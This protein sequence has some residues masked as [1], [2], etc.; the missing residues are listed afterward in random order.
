MAATSVRFWTARRGRSR[1]VMV[2]AAAVLVLGVAG[3]AAAAI[4][5]RS[6]VIVG[7]YKT[8]GGGLRVIDPSVTKCKSTE[9]LL[10]WNQRGARGPAGPAGARGARGPAGPAGVSG[11]E[12]V[13]S[14]TD[15]L[16]TSPGVIEGSAFVNCPT[17]KRVFGG[18]AVFVVNDELGGGP[19][20]GEGL[21]ITGSNPDPEGT[22]WEVNYR[23]DDNS[24]GF[25][26][27][28]ETYATCATVS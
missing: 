24:K 19:V 5:T 18:G 9:T 27:V 14:V 3:V 4:P 8:S 20:S 25:I 15:K 12:V 28:V 2:V 16:P 21:A 17:G 11:Y 13:R 23:I 1:V 7:C 26:A 6:G 10:K 22:R